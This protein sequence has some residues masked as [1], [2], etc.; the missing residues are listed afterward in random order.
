MPMVRKHFWI[1]DPE[2][3]RARQISSE[4]GRERQTVIT[5]IQSGTYSLV[6]QQIPKMRGWDAQDAL[7]LRL[8]LNVNTLL[9]GF[10]A[11]LPP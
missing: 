1:F 8:A 4:S 11:V 7:C 2:S 6:I 9:L 3:E 10:P 5:C